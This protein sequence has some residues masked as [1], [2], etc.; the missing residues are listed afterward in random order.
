MGTPSY[1]APEQADGHPAGKPA[2]VYALGAILYRLLTGRV[3]F[4][5]ESWVDVLHDVRHKPPQPP[6]ELVPG[7]PQ[8]LE[9]LCL[10]CL[11]KDADKRPTAAELAG[12]LEQVSAPLTPTVTFHEAPPV[13]PRRR[14]WVAV[15]VLAL[16]VCAGLSGWTMWPKTKPVMSDLP[17]TEPVPLEP[18]KGFL[19]AEMRREGDRLR[20]SSSRWATPPRDRCVRGT[21]SASPSS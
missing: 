17:K 6:S 21:R 18:L 5:R 9:A 11:E 7:I 8:G 16:L 20:S 14:V 15:G 1:M 3:V 2:D 13:R 12:E 4:P 10:R 19:D